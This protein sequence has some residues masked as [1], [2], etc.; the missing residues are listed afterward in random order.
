MVETSDKDKLVA[1]N[2][3]LQI[4]RTQLLDT[5]VKDTIQIQWQQLI[6]IA[7]TARFWKPGPNP[8]K[9]IFILNLFWQYLPP[10]NFMAFISHHPIKIFSAFIYSTLEFKHSN[11][12]LILM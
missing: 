12:L 11:W 10:V 2:I 1:I 9:N 3:V 6:F 5:N 4:N 8:I 7:D